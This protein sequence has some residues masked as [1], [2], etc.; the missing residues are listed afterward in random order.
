MKKKERKEEPTRTKTDLLFLYS[1]NCY[2]A[3]TLDSCL[4]YQ[5]FIA[6]TTFASAGF[7]ACK[8]LVAVL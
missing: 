3:P 5:G 2:V 7:G 8:I 6:Q 4:A 1:G